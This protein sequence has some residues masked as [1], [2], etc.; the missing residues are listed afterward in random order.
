MSVRRVIFVTDPLCSWCWGMAP[1][2]A[3]I[4]KTLAGRLDFDVALGGIN[5]GNDS[6]L[7]ESA[8]ARFHALW[9]QVTAVTGQQFSMRLPVDPAFVYNSRPACLGVMA[10]REMNDVPPFDFLESMQRAFFVEARNVTSTRVMGEIAMECGIDEQAFLDAL[11]S[12]AILRAVNAEMDSCRRYGT[13]A[14]PA[15][16]VETEMGRRLFAGGYVS[17]DFLLQGLEDWLEQNP[18]V[19]N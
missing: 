1:E 3:R 12:D 14:L 15:V 4:R 8:I 9:E 13:Q 10:A 7:R 17:H 18:P 2:I 16:L 6:R 11:S 19:V 5:V